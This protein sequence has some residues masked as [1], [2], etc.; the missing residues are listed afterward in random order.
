[1]AFNIVMLVCY[2]AF[3]LVQSHGYCSFSECLIPSGWLDFLAVVGIIRAVCACQLEVW[4]FT[5]V[6]PK[7]NVVGSSSSM[8]QSA[9]S[10][11]VLEVS[12]P[13]PILAPCLWPVK[14]KDENDLK[15]WDGALCGRPRS[16]WLLIWI[17]KAS[18]VAVIYRVNQKMKDVSVFPLPSICFS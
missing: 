6:L 8:L 1:M 11:S 7:W 13:L 18:S 3:P 4:E 10:L 15:H 5:W 17:D 2:S 12:A 9:F 16:P 14:K